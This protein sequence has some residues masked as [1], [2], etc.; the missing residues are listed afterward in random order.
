MTTMMMTTVTFLPGWGALPGLVRKKVIPRMSLWPLN[1]PRYTPPPPAPPPR[2][3]CTVSLASHHCR[4]HSVMWAVMIHNSH[5]DSELLCAGTAIVCHTWSNA[6]CA[7]EQAVPGKRAAPSKVNPQPSKKAKA[8]PGAG[9]AAAAKAQT[10]AAASQS[11]QSLPSPC[12]FDSHAPCACTHA[13]DPASPAASSGTCH[14]FVGMEALGA[15][16]PMRL[17]I[18]FRGNAPGHKC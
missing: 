3:S 11:G 5:H 2:F 8:A 10:A 16:F 17:V 18:S 7:C 15:S 1:L 6:W 14:G 4:L 12:F 9:P 13:T